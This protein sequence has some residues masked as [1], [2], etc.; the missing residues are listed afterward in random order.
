MIQPQTL[1]KIT[2]NSGGKVG[3]VFKVLGGSKKRYA[4]LGELSYKE[5]TK[6][7]MDIVNNYLS[8]VDTTELKKYS[9]SGTSPFERMISNLSICVVESKLE[10]RRSI[11]DASELTI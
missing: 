2:D 8:K 11:A 10:S 6:Y 4:E 1:V 3:R 7:Y 9:K 5:P